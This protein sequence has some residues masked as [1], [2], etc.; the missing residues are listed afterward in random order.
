MPLIIEEEIDAVSSGDESDAE[1]M[2]T[3]MLEDIFESSQSHLSI[4]MREVRY[5]IRYLIKQRQAEWKG[6]LLS[7]RDMGEGLHKVFKAVVNEISQA[8]PILGESGSEASYF[9]P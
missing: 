7:M 2:S 1:P 8:L 9:I 6:A 3:D 5:K 4:N